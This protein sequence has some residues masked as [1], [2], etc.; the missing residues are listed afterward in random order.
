MVSLLHSFTCQGRT[1]PSA[2]AAGP[3]VA[4]RSAGDRGNRFLGLRVSSVS[5]AARLSGAGAPPESV[6]EKCVFCL[7]QQELLY[8]QTTGEPD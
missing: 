6:L 8:V 3:G 4:R 5:P 1:L 2:L 7:A